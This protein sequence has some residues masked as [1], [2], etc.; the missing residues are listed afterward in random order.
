MASVSAIGSKKWAAQLVPSEDGAF[1]ID[2]EHDRILKLNRA[3][4]DIW[5]L[6]SQ[7]HNEFQ[8][9]HIISQKYGIDQS[10][11][12]ADVKPILAKI[13]ELQLSPE[14]TIANPEEAKTHT[15]EQTQPFYPWYGQIAGDKTSAKPSLLIVLGA[16][17]GLSLFD[18]LLALYS[19]KYL[20]ACVA[21]WPIRKRERS[22]SEIVGKVCAAVQQACVWYPKRSLCLQRSA[23]TACLLRLYGLSAQM[24]VGI[25]DMP[26]MAHAWVQIDDQVINDWPGVRSFYRPLTTQTTSAQL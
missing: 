4:T 26:F 7:G 23:V 19:L 6:L 17:F 9:V 20:C 5:H 13:A 2:I 1:L 22:D 16:L 12:A 25:R 15:Q 21:S 10:R 3:G 8:I 11:A 14:Q 18:M 24:V